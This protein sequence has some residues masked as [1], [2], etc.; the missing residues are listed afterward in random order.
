MGRSQKAGKKK[1]WSELSGGQRLGIVAGAIV[2]FTLQGL[3]L[4]DLARRPASQVNGPKLAW[5]AGTFINTV[6][7]IAYFLLGRRPANR[8]PVTGR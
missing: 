4:R 7:P 3:A 8:G 5:A 6:G 1:R 2:Q